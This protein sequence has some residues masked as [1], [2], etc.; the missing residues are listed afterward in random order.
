MS[1][2]LRNLPVTTKLYSKKQENCW[3][4]DACLVAVLKQQHPVSKT[5]CK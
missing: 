3:R 2:A 5:K 4:F 1:K